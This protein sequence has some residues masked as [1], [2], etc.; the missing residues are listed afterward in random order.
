M[1][2]PDPARDVDLWGNNAARDYAQE[3]QAGRKWAYAPIEEV[4]ANI[5]STGYPMDRVVFV[6]GPVEETIPAVLPDRICILR[7]DTDWYRST[8]HEMQHL[9]PKL[10]AQGVLAVDDYGHYR[11]A[12]QAVDEFLGMQASKPLLH[13]TDYSCVFAIKPASARS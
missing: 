13:R 1:T 12:Q 6:K 2:A 3:H 10:V 8:L 11:G 4:R 5:A 7:L 9:Y